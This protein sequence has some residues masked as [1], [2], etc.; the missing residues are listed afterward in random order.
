MAYLDKT[1][2]RVGTRDIDDA[3][4]RGVFVKQLKYSVIGDSNSVIP[5]FVPF[6]QR[7]YKYDPNSIN[8]TVLLKGSNYPYQLSFNPNPNN[9]IYIY[10]TKSDLLKFDSTDAVWGYLSAPHLHDTI[11]LDLID[12]RSKKNKIIKVWE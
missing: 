11:L 4:K 6:I 8:E 5:G 7:G 3:V 9:D 10:I 12:T 1:K 2:Y